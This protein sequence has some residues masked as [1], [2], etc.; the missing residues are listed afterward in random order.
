MEGHASLFLTPISLGFRRIAVMGENVRTGEGGKK[1]G[2]HRRKEGARKEGRGIEGE[3][4]QRR[5]GTGKEET[6]VSRALIHQT[7]FDNKRIDVHEYTH[8]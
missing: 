5:L 2:G 7:E 8:T 3:E 6:R 4:G 1:E